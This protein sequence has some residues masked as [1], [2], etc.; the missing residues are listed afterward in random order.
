M[1]SIGNYKSGEDTNDTILLALV[2]EI[3]DLNH[4]ITCIWYT[5]SAKTFLIVLLQ[6]TKYTRC[7][8]GSWE[9]VYTG[10]VVH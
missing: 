9:V 5:N 8:Y 1:F 2:S 10:M 4:E 6:N 3:W 7:N